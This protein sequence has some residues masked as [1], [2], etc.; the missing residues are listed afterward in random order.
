MGKRNN[1]VK[2]LITSSEDGR[3]T[4]REFTEIYRELFDVTFRDITVFEDA[5]ETARKADMTHM[6]YFRDVRN[7]TLTSFADEMGGYSLDITVDDL[8]RVLS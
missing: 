1:S 7:L 8:R 6:L 5:L 2:V 3:N 4:A